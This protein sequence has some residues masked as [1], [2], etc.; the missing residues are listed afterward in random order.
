MKRSGIEGLYDWLNTWSVMPT[1]KWEWGK[2][3]DRFATTWCVGWW[4]VTKF[5]RG[6]R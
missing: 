4:S 1:G 2:H 5:K 6:D 3:E